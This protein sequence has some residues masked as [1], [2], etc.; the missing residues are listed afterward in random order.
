[1]KSYQELLELEVE[2]QYNLYDAD[3]TILA[4]KEDA[5]F[6]HKYGTEKR[7]EIQ[8]DEAIIE[9]VYLDGEEIE[10][11]GPHLRSWI[12][13]TAIESFLDKWEYGE[14]K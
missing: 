6:D 4:H 10:E 2:Y 9:R 14:F 12:E 5:S 3:V 13:K 1:M 7:T 11:I 8:V